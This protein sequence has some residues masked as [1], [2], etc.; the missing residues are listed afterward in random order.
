MHIFGTE[1]YDAPVVDQNLAHRPVGGQM[2]L[3]GR[4]SL[5]FGAVEGSNATLGYVSTMKPYIIQ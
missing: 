1:D 5:Q 3:E 4:I 2:R